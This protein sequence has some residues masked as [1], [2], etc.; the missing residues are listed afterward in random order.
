MVIF[1][2]SSIT[3]CIRNRNWSWSQIHK[4]YFRLHNTAVKYT[5][6]I[7]FLVGVFLLRLDC[8]DMGMQTPIIHKN[9]PEKKG[10]FM[11]EKHW[12]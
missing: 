11:E 8:I 7:A 2:I 5:N 10:S 9:L 1:K 12:I 3:I 6:L 4:K